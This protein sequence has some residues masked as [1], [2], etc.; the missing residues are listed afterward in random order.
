[1]SWNS[2]FMDGVWWVGMSWPDTWKV[3]AL[4][5]SLMNIYL[6][7]VYYLTVWLCLV[8]DSA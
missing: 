4:K 3:L 8:R 6:H 7:D 1:M 2:I 5:V